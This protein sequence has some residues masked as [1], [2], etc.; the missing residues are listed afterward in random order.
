[1]PPTDLDSLLARA[2]ATEFY[3]SR[4]AASSVWKR[5]PLTQRAEL[6]RD[7]LAHRPLG[8]RRYADAGTPVRAGIC[9]SGDDLL[10][11]A[12]NEE[13]L[14]H[15]RH[16]GVRMLARL[17]IAPGTAIANTLAGAL[18]SPGS[19]LLGDVVEEHGSLDVPLGAIE[20]DAAARQAW[21]LV[22]RVTP[23]ILFL[24]TE[25]TKR[26]FDA[27]PPAQRPWLK[28]LVWLQRGRVAAVP[29]VTANVGFG[30]WSRSWLAIPEAASFAAA[31][32]ATERFHLDEALAVEVEGGA[33][34]VTPLTGSTALLRYDTGLPASALEPCECGAAGTTLSLAVVAGR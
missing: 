1:M 21:E 23:A 17:G 7:Q 18:T 2:G 19:L 34:I 12:W 29:E 13:D 6:V 24:E 4:A 32:C 5:V 15:E 31:S 16:A 22:D 33:L 20:S 27:A 3:R 30:G 8:T 26:L 10:V 14:Q 11:L 28:G 25:T 9:G